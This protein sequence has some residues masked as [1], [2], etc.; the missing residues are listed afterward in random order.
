MAAPSSRTAR[1]RGIAL[2]GAILL[3]AIVTALAIGIGQRGGFTI[4]ATTRVIE[5]TR[6][7]EVF[8]ALED[9]ARQALYADT[10]D[11]DIDSADEAWA[12]DTLVVQ[13]GAGRGRLAD[14]QGRFNLNNLAP[15][16]VAARPADAAAGTPDAAAT[17]PG[18]APATNTGEAAPRARATLPGG[19]P[20]ADP[21]MD[22]PATDHAPQEADT[23]RPVFDAS[24]LSV[25]ER[26]RQL[27]MLPAPYVPQDG[28]AGASAAAGAAA[29]PRGAAAGE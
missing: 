26:R 18:A 21:G 4:A 27:A 9:A 20:P 11:S 15:S 8:L 3:A 13:D 22:A 6:A 24:T 28:A 1:Q 25:S 23:T 2:L 19:P 12:A 14:L 7:D 16:A 10:I 17:A 29:Q 5:S